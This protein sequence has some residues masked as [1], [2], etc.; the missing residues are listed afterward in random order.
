M[1]KD[2]SFYIL[3]YDPW[4]TNNSNFLSDFKI[5]DLIYIAIFNILH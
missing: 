3:I 2:G 5:V 4:F 1:G